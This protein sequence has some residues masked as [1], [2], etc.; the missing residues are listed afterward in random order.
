MVAG[1]SQAIMRIGSQL[2]TRRPS[3]VKQQALPTC[4]T[5]LPACT[6]PPCQHLCCLVQSA[7]AKYVEHLLCLSAKRPS[8]ADQ[9]CR[10]L[11]VTPGN[12]G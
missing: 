8:F 3:D 7:W 12:L 9:A 4:V 10:G 11:C 6:H 5:L 1:G 2:H